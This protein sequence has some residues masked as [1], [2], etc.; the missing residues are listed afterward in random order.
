MWVL[1]FGA[2]SILPSE[3]GPFALLE[4]L[5]G[6]PTREDHIHLQLRTRLFPATAPAPLLSFYGFLFRYFSPTFPSLS[7]SQALL[8]TSEPTE[9]CALILRSTPRCRAGPLVLL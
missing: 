4:S 5:D 7:L 6:K 8:G 2:L 9:A 3:T 1:C